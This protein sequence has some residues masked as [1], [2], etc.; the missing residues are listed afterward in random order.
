MARARVR[1]RTSAVAHGPGRRLASLPEPLL[2]LFAEELGG[3]RRVLSLCAA[4]LGAEGYSPPL[5]ARLLEIAAGRKGDRWE[6]R[7]LAALML[8]QQV[9][10]LPASDLPELGGLLVRLGLKKPG[11]EAPL[12]E[13]VL[14]EG[15]TRRDLPGFAREL[16]RRLERARRVLDGV[17]GPETTPAALRAFL[18]FARRECKLAL[19]RYLFAPEEVVARILTLVKVSRG[20][21][22]RSSSPHVE[23]EARRV[24]D[25]LPPYE[26]QIL[27]LLIGPSARIYWA[28]QA[29]GG[30]L[31]SLV[32]YPL[33]TVVLVVKPPGSDLEIEIKRAGRRGGPPLS[34][35]FERGDEQVPPSHRLDGGSILGALHWE[36]RA[37]SLLA[38]I[39]RQVHGGEAP[40]SRTLAI[41]AVYG[42]PCNGG[43]AHVLDYF[44]SARHF[45]PGFAPMRKAMAAATEAFRRENKRD[46]SDLEGNLG[47][48]SRFLYHAPP[49]QAILAETS[50]F[51]LDQ[52]VRY[53]SEHGPAAYFRSRPRGKAEPEL[54][55]QLADDV[56]E[57]ILGVHVRPEGKWPGYSRYLAAAFALPANRARADRVYRRLMRQVGALWGTLCALRGFTRGESF[58][59]RNVGLK[60]RWEGGR[61]QVGIVFMDHDNLQ[62]GDGPPWPLQ[63]VRGM[64]TDD[65]YLRG[66]P[67]SG[68]TG[69]TGLL[70]EIYRTSEE[71]ARAGKT[72]MLRAMAGAYRKTLRAL[73]ADRRIRRLLPQSLLSEVG[74]WETAVRHYLRRDPAADGAW[75]ER[76]CRYLARKGH[77]EERITNYLRALEDQGR[78][79]ETLAP[80]YLSR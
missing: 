5:A 23:E 58:V 25:R 17:G 20:V 4:F 35:V 78:L 49:G 21:P 73:R 53:L 11:I 74:D 8:Q 54:L 24:L 42:V 6:V 70:R 75:K 61:W 40:L 1:D 51:R 67:R 28:S 12:R 19:A 44:T 79:L 2:S 15:Y 48:T 64:R 66:R 26:A 80:L 52:L 47:L 63:I 9:L 16:R 30:A 77:S 76:V 43:E 22:D 10:R 60:S 13:S 29:T 38:A 36:A 57:E 14:L 59:A 27:R 72:E 18:A 34:A 3:N 50:S 65:I 37:G 68:I 31:N 55:R 39:H 69:S 45:G 46:L 32:E 71:T 56:L 33:D 62:L 7:R 41:A